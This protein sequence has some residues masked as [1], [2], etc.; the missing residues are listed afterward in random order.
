MGVSDVEKTLEP[1]GDIITVLDRDG[2]E[3]MRAVQQ[4][5]EVSISG[6]TG[7]NVIHP[8]LLELV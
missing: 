7:L 4:I 2:K 5:V 3:G 1:I 6:R 8:R